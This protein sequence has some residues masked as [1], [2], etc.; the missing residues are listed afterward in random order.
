MQVIV[1][2]SED[3]TW[4]SEGQLLR[5]KTNYNSDIRIL[6]F[7]PKGNETLQALEEYILFIT[8]NTEIAERLKDSVEKLAK[9]IP[10]ESRVFSL[11]QISEVGGSE[12]LL[13]ITNTSGLSNYYNRETVY[14]EGLHKIPVYASTS[15]V[16]DTFLIRQEGKVWILV[17]V[18]FA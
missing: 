4:P 17:E 6:R 10:K 15:L 5:V 7:D 2:E 18:I 16:V 9:Y 11:I 1:V 12:R 3:N 8:K 13:K 14:K